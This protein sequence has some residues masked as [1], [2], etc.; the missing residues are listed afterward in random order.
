VKKPPRADLR[1]G[2]LMRPA[3]HR[4]AEVEQRVCSSTSSPSEVKQQ[5]V[6]SRRVAAGER[7]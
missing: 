6:S 4:G 1:S 3:R 7:G 2:A 5:A